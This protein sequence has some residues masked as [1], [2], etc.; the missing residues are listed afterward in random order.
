MY[1]SNCSN[2]KELRRTATAKGIGIIP[3]MPIL[4]IQYWSGPIRP[5]EAAM[6]TDH[7]CKGFRTKSTKAKRYTSNPPT[8]AAETTDPTWYKI[9]IATCSE[10]KP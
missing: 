2:F 8:A 1:T 7:Q 4:G 3:K 10:S 6:P 9:Y 5:V